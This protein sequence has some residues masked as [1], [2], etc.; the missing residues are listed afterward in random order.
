M[1]IGVAIPC[2]Y[3]H[4]PHLTY[5]L[6]SIESQTHR[7]D[8]VVVSC[9]STTEPVETKQ[10]S[11]PLEIITTEHHK[12]AAQNRNIAASKLLDMDYITFMDAD[13][14]MHPQ[15]IEILLRVFQETDCDIILHNFSTGNLDSSYIQNIDMRI[16]QLTQ[17]YSGC[18]RHVNL[19]NHQLQLIHHSQSS[20]KK[21]IFDI[22]KYPEEKEYARKEDCAF[23]H[24]VFGIP[25]IKNVYIANELSLY[26]PSY[27]EF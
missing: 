16:N 10:Y 14:R 3:G 18:I 15:R 23:C 21:N 7:P 9:S 17:C 1:K 12:N 4:I 26:N 13:D 2:Y 6:D 20:I 8:K 27:T 11:F 25:N 19:Y 24:R 5:L 22:V